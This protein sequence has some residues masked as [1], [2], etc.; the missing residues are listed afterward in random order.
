MS[1]RRPYGERSG[2]HVEWVTIRH[3]TIY[4]LLT[5]AVIVVGAAAASYY[6]VFHASPEV[7]TASDPAEVALSTSASFIE[8]SGSVK[9]RKAGT[10]AWIDAR[11]GIPLSRDD[12]VRTDSKATARIRFFDGTE[13]LV[14][15]DT[16]LVI[17]ESYEDPRT[18]VRRVAVKLTAGQVNL[19]TPTRN[20]EG[21][22]SELA[23]P[24]TEARFE[25][26]TVADVRYDQTNRV[27]GFTIFRGATDLKAGGKRVKLGSSQ[28]VEVSG[29]NIFSEIIR[30]PGIPSL[31]TPV[32]LSTVVHRDPT[33]SNTE[34]KWS[35][36][37][38]ARRYRVM[39]D[40]TPNFSD[41]LWDSKV[42]GLTAIVPGLASGTY[43]WKVSAEDADNRQGGYSDFA[44]FRISTRASTN[45]PPK[46]LVSKPIATLDGVV[47][48]NGTTDPDAVV[49]VNNERVSVRPDGSFQHYFII[50]RPGRHEII[51]RAYKRSGGTA[52][53]VFQV[54]I[55]SEG[56]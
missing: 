6:F 3:R 10:Y 34:L 53:K 28:E 27:S 13:Y 47:T 26:R 51:V 19:Q 29:E 11:M 1:Q 2:L 35:S 15:R 4:V 8:I 21:S 56:P 44:K 12:H 17:E 40:R 32:H 9:V 48:F 7:G 25:E 39:L 36:V 45:T 14:K 5:T 41:P 33:R 42:R 31:K 43:Y 16:I 46:L 38:G 24:N 49:T 52:E 20:V 30:L 37:E 23:T 18:N 55:G 54:T 50:G 22:S